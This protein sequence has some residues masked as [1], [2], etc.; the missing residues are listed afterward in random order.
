[1]PCTGIPCAPRTSCWSA[2]MH[3]AASSMRRTDAITPLHRLPAG[4]PGGPAL[5]VDDLPLHVEAADEE[6][7]ALVL[8]ILKDRPRVLAHQDRV[9]WIV[10]D[11]E[12]VADAV[13]LADPVQGD[14]RAG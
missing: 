4:S 9:R 14:P 10:V 5:R 2:C 7:V 13:L 1:M 12:L 6:V 8:Q 11:A 3:A